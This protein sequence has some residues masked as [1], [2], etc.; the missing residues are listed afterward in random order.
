MFLFALARIIL[1][2]HEKGTYGLVKKIAFIEHTWAKFRCHF[3]FECKLCERKLS[4]LTFKEGQLLTPI[5]IYP[6][7]IAQNLGI[8]FL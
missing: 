6:K 1:S 4:E 3:I 7:L 2:H 5:L 8:N